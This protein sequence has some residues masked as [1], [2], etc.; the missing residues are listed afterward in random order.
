ML[1]KYGAVKPKRVEQMF[2]RLIELG[3]AQEIVWG[4]ELDGAFSTKWGKWRLVFRYP[5]LTIYDRTTSGDYTFPWSQG[6]V[7]LRDVLQRPPVEIEAWLTA[8][9]GEGEE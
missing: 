7:R 4:R 6:A 9:L 8:L 3:E 5:F 2:D 1:T